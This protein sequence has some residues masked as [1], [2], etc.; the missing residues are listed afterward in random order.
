M[1][2]YE[3][4]VQCILDELRRLDLILQIYHLRTAA[5]RSNEDP[6]RGRY[7]SDEEAAALGCKDRSLRR[8]FWLP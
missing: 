4:D 8:C 5:L 6:L 7:I 1:A 3:D 2:T